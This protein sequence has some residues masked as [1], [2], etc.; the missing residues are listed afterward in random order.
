MKKWLLGLMVVFCIAFAAVTSA[1]SQ[2]PPA[3]ATAVYVQ[4]YAGIVSSDTENR[5]H[6]LGSQLA[7]KTKA[8]VV[9]V[10]VKSLNGAVI[11]DFALTI[12]RQWGIGDKQLNNG[13][14]LLVSV[15]DRQSRIEVGY[16]L[17][18]VL[19]DSKTGRIQDEYLIPWLRQGDYD[20]GILN[21]YLAVVGEVAKEYKLQLNTDAKPIARSGT[22]VSEP[23][24]FDSLPWWGQIL[25]GFAVLGFFLF[26]WFFLGGAI[27]YLL[28]SLIR[29]RGGGGGGRG[30][31]G[32]GGGSGGGG[33][34]SRKW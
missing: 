28:L 30:G 32:W 6:N 26:D 3:P 34:S 23:S 18:G 16:G 17:E 22:A 4:D 10:T 9:V 1:Q 24:W 19:P 21:C 27:T 11:E 12:L 8:Q 31:G 29:S 2:V 14:L 13:V 5:I 33:G 25:V 20:K 7:N 15:G